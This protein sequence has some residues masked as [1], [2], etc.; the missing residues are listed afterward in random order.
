VKRARGFTYIEV[1]VVI[2]ITLL[3]AALVMPNLIARKRSRDEWSFRTHL[4]SLGK[5][6]RSRA[7]EIGRM[8]SLSFDKTKNEVQVI[9]IDINGAEKQTQ[10]LAV[11][12]WLTP[13]RFVA[14]QNE[15]IGDSWRVPF[16]SDGASSGGGIEFKSDQG[17]WSLVVSP[18]DQTIKDLDGP[19]PDFTYE[20]WP[21]GSNVAPSSS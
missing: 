8:V 15:S 17:S 12:D 13:E 16:Y 10:A 6:A 9:E 7:I 4:R 5:D 14:D 19:M 3:L 1:L 2:L 21:A 11:P 20:T 18:L